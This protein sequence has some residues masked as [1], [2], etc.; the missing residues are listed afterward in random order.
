V[1]AVL[2]QGVVVAGFCFIVWIHLLQRY[3]ASRLGAFSFTTP[4]LGVTLSVLLVGDTLAIEH[5]ASVVLVAAGILI[6]ERA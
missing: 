6:V 3:S 5:L 4:V 2:Y 1:G